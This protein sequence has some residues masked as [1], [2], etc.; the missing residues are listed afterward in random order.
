MEQAGYNVELFVITPDTP[1]DEYPKL[2]CFTAVSTQYWQVKHVAKYIKS[3][4]S[5]IFCLL[6]GHEASMNSQ[7]VIEQG[8]FDAICVSEGE[9]AVM[10]IAECLES[11][12]INK[13]IYNTLLIV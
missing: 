12:F 9:K 8:V 4:D 11:R 10:E 2:F 6:G 7:K 5:S 13:D 1:L 3:V